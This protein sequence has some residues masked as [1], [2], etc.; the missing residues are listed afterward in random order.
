MPFSEHQFG[1]A[2]RVETEAGHESPALLATN[3]QNSAR[4]LPE[5]CNGGPIQLTH[6]V[7]G[8]VGFDQTLRRMVAGREIK[9]RR[10][11]GQTI[12]EAAAGPSIHGLVENVPHDVKGEQ[13]WAGW[14]AWAAHLAK[15]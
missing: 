4:A 12:P 2:P 6:T 13:A 11:K 8:Q 15:R 14:P 9:T 5:T 10:S 1:G 7:K 3:Q